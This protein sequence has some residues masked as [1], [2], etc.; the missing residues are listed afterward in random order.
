MSSADGVREVSF[1]A[2]GAISTVV[3]AMQAH[4]SDA[5][6]RGITAKGGADRT[7][8]VASVSRFTAIVNAMGGS[9]QRWGCAAGGV[10]DDGGSDEFS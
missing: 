8:V 7:M 5:S 2:S 10:Y 4:V 6:L 9:I 3:S 1:A